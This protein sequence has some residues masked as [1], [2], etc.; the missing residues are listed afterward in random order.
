MQDPHG[1]RAAV[2]H[3]Q[4]S[5]VCSLTALGQ[6]I[7]P[8]LRHAVDMATAEAA[9]RVAE[10]AAQRRL[11]GGSAAVLPSQEASLLVKEGEDCLLAANFIM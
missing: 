3:L 2:Q 5:L 8:G 4:C 1:F 7:V 11:M 9:E 6:L 10:A